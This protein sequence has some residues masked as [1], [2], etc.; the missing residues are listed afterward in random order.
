M[1]R[2]MMWMGGYDEARVL[3]EW[4]KIQEEKKR[5]E[6]VEAKIRVPVPIGIVPVMEA[7]MIAE[8]PDIGIACANV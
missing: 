6:A 1:Q 7:T 2:H 8:T 5:M 4:A 3:S